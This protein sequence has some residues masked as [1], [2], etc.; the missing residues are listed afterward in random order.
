MLPPLPPCA[1]VS[2]HLIPNIYPSAIWWCLK[3]WTASSSGRGCSRPYGM[4]GI[5][6]WSPLLHRYPAVRVRGAALCKATRCGGCTT[7][8]PH[9]CRCATPASNRRPCRSSTSVSPDVF[10]TIHHVKGAC[11][12]R[13]DRSGWSRLCFPCAVLFCRRNGLQ[14]RSERGGQRT[15][16]PMGLA[17]TAELLSWVVAF[18]APFGLSL[19]CGNAPR[20]V[21]GQVP[22]PGYPP[23]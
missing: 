11:S 6:F 7:Y 20:A 5:G 14:K 19:A 4:P 2:P 1:Y 3:F 15:C 23:L 12:P 10:A 18:S 13:R 22:N 17:G 8:R 9:R 16:G 21:R